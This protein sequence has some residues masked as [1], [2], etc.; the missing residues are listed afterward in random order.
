MPGKTPP[1]TEQAIL[2]K[3]DYQAQCLLRNVDFRKDLL[4]FRQR[5]PLLFDT[6][7]LSPGEREGL[8]RFISRVPYLG[9]RRLN[10]THLA[11]I[12]QELVGGPR[13][14]LS[15]P[16]LH[17]LFLFAIQSQAP[18]VR[19]VAPS[20]NPD[21]YC[22]ALGIEPSDYQAERARLQQRWP[23]LPD[24]AWQPAIGLHG[25]HRPSLIFWRHPNFLPSLQTALETP[26]LLTHRSAAQLLMPFFRE[27]VAFF[28]DSVLDRFKHAEL[29][30]P[31]YA[32]TRGE[33]PDWTE[34]ALAQ[35]LLYGHKRRSRP[36]LYN[37][38]LKAY[39]LLHAEPRPHLRE[40]AKE[41]GCSLDQAVRAIRRGYEDITG[42]AYPGKR[43]ARIEAAPFAR[44]FQTCGVCGLAKG[45]HNGLCDVGDNLL[46]EEVGVAPLRER[47]VQTGTPEVLQ[48]IRKRPRSD[49]YGQAQGARLARKPRRK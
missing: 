9:V 8:V 13:S 49:D 43:T 46:N 40:I 45:T 3:Q 31:I 20:S 5:F 21:E 19:Y 22:A 2:T 15:S 48:K 16:S 47:L 18:T 26:E 1:D 7:H 34:I 41:L 14:R 25:V 28:Q 4:A 42:S 35:K 33:D 12:P 44:H 39:D 23:Q 27:L 37:R 24:D 38:Y 17:D 36:N 11:I 6:A 10:A 29:Y 30:V 32:D